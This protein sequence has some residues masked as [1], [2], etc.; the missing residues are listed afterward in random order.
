MSNIN[1]LGQDLRRVS[2]YINTELCPT[3]LHM[4]VVWEGKG[5]L[6]VKQEVSRYQVV[7]LSGAGPEKKIKKRINILVGD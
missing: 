3:E 1:F 4:S 2:N 6:K 5:C 7:S